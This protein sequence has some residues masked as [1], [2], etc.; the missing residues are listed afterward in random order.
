MAG[1]DFPRGVASVAL[2]VDFAAERGVPPDDVLKG[3]GLDLSTVRNPYA[4]AE[5]RQ[6]LAV[7]RNLLARCAGSDAELGSDLGRRY[8]ATVYGIWGFAVTSSRTVGDAM[9]LALRYVELTYVFCVPDLRVEGDLAV[10]DCRT[11]TVPADVR[12]FLLARDVAAIHTL[13]EDLLG[14]TP[15]PPLRCG[16]LTLPRELL[17]RPM[18][19]AN[20][21]TAAMCE[22]QCRNLLAERRARDGVARTVRDRLLA[23]DGLGL[24]MAAVAAEL[25]MTTRTLRR[26]L[27]AEGAGFRALL[28]EVRQALAEELLATRSM[29]VEQVAHRLGY[30][31]AAAFVRAFMRWTGVSPGRYARTGRGKRPVPRRA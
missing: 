28:D 22:E 9:R 1:W 7:V 4:Q 31:D 25:G 18:P 12:P 30:G 14:I 2:L 8:H 23:V 27:A 29:S 16:T 11:D 5:A 10:L 13:I 15:T 24:G 26:R 19:Q 21:H 17:D 3:T 6:E 20:D